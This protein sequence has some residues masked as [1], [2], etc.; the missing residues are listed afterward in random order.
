MAMRRTEVLH[1]AIQMAEPSNNREEEVRE[2]TWVVA[3][4]KVSIMAEVDFKVDR[5]R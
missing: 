2:G 5:H 1:T 3:I 4:T